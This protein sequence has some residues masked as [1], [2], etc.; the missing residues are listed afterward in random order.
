M[1]GGHRIKLNGVHNTRDLGGY[2]TLDGRRI[3]N[4]HLIRSGELMNTTK[5]DRETLFET[6]GVAKV[7][8]F[9]TDLERSRKP[10][11]LWPGVEWV[12]NPILSA[13]VMG[14]STGQAKE[15]DGPMDMF[16]G[17]AASLKGN[18]ISYISPLYG[19]LALNEFAVSQYRR[20]FELLIEHD[21]EKG[22]VLWHCSAGK[23]RVGIGTALLLLALGA[24]RELVIGDY[25]KSNEYM[26]DEIEAV[27]RLAYE[28]T[29][30]R[31]V[32]ETVM[33]LDGVAREYIE[34]AF[35]N[36]EESY[37]SVENYLEKAMGLTAERRNLLKNK[38]L[39]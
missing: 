26:K 31:A 18:A 14:I 21:N 17:H 16:I 30:D 36:M 34:T 32:A 12:V 7:I 27:G 8:D 10:D 24:D 25:L 38:Y 19:N 28:K 3:K 33:I 9:R 20:F 13:E 4:R 29:G 5:E 35:E 37:G 6:C 2:Q 39:E 23:D 22:P 11:P 1:D 15:G